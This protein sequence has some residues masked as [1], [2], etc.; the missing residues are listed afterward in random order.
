MRSEISILTLFV[1]ESGKIKS[2][3]IETSLST[4]SYNEGG[5]SRHASFETLKRLPTACKNL[6]NPDL[7]GITPETV[8]QTFCLKIKLIPVSLPILLKMIRISTFSSSI[9][10]MITN[11]KADTSKEPLIS[12]PLNFLKKSFSQRDTYWPINLS[13][14]RLERISKLLFLLNFSSQLKLVPKS[15]LKPTLKIP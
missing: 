7:T 4:R 10:D 14:R 9:V 8:I 2:E 1:I 5:V 11:T 15:K 6:K 13:L 12:L 3:S